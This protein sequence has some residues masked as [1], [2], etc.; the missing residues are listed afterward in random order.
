MA[1]W[2]DDDPKVI[3]RSDPSS[4][5]SIEPVRSQVSKHPPGMGGVVLRGTTT[6]FWHFANGPALVSL[7]INSAFGIMT[8]SS[9]DK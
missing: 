2:I 5:D 3:C 1:R 4:R 6:V 7:E 8:G 9:R